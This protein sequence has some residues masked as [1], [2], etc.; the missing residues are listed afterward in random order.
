MSLRS[1]FPRIHGL[2]SFT[3]QT[4]FSPPVCILLA[5]GSVVLGMVWFFLDFFAGMAVIDI[6]SW[7]P[8]IVALAVIDLLISEKW[9]TA[10]IAFPLVII[11]LA[12][13]YYVLFWL[14]TLVWLPTPAIGTSG[15]ILL[16]LINGSVLWV[17]YEVQLV[18]SHKQ[19][20]V[21]R[22]RRF[23]RMLPQTA[24]A[25][26]AGGLF[27]KTY[28]WDDPSRQWWLSDLLP[29]NGA[30]LKLT[31][32]PPISH[33]LQ[34]ASHLTSSIVNELRS[35][36]AVAEVIQAV[37]DA[38][39]SGR[40]I[41][42]SG[43]RHSM[44]GQALGSG[45]LHLDMTHMDAVRYNNSDQ[46][47]TVGPGATWKQIQMTLSPHGRAVRVMQDSNIFSVGGS[48]S[49]NTHG[50]DPRYGS[51]IES[52]NYVKLVMADGRE[53]RCDRTQQSNLFAAVIGGYGILG[54]ITE[55]NLRTTQ[56][57]G[58]V[59]SLIPTQT[60]S[61]I[62]K[63]EELGKDPA[64]RLIEAH[65]SVDREHFL[66]EG[67]IY[68]YSESKSLPQPADD[69]QGEN[70]IWLRK[71]VFQAS[72][73]SNMGKILRWELEKRLTPLVDPKTVSR[74]TAMAVPVRF[75]Q[76][77][78]PQ[79]TDILQEY[80]IPTE[81]TRDFL[82]NYKRL[83][84]KHN[85]N[86]LNVTIR[87]VTQDTNA[88]VSYAQTNMYGFVVYYKVSRR[89]KEIQTLQAF[90]SELIEY[91]ISIKARYYLCYGSYYSQSQLIS[92]YPEIHTLF[93]RKSQYDP[94]ELFTN[95]WYEKYHEAFP[96]R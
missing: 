43:I 3:K 21:Q 8:L 61:V 62:E 36:R 60:D 72:R 20:D 12:C 34:D 89:S 93:T 49:V 10:V 59:F 25:L 37:R 18:R 26:A 28:F 79:T 14:G 77:P 5:I 47:I 94:Q 84:H 68:N 23:F 6:Y 51:L 80:F 50:K 22:R 9:I 65:L 67:L 95:E 78:D 7:L 58:Y 15:M 66:T 92:M 46:T 71:V 63:L 27:I 30:G 52:V 39:L 76:N 53:I 91:L 13:L 31:L 57:N 1:L 81:Q 41:S 2:A 75:L 11:T 19:Q 32:A 29:S 64:N 55:V 35:P 56:N 87:K 88:L 54:I 42:L 24:L 73:A 38:R 40:K 86:L 48:L 69:L 70:S 17:T 45:T 33:H 85:I 90:T 96:I 82:E 4:I 44:G 83:L 74:N 16:M